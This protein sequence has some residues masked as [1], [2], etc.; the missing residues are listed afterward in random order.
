MEEIIRK[1][2]YTHKKT[3]VEEHVM[4]AVNH[5]G[6]SV[7]VWSGKD[8]GVSDSDDRDPIKY[9]KQE[10]EIKALEDGIKG[11][12]GIFIQDQDTWCLK[13]GDNVHRCNSKNNGYTRVLPV[14]TTSELQKDH[15]ETTDNSDI[16]S[17]R[18]SGS[19][20]ASIM[21]SRERYNDSFINLKQSSE[22][23]FRLQDE[24]TAE[25]VD[26][27]RSIRD[28]I[29]ST[30]EIHGVQINTLQRKETELELLY[31]HTL[32]LLEYADYL[33]DIADKMGKMH[34]EMKKIRNVS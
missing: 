25:L 8:L 16:S 14:V 10:V 18:I 19:L 6:S 13:H 21:E 26:T 24:F 7:I 32:E 4:E 28:E 1:S 5:Y 34:I 31:T 3:Y 22:K 12:T 27:T 30:G 9:K 23:F 17:S 11:L 20:L 15:V 29:Q 2:G 33:N